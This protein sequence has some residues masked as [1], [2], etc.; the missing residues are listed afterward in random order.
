MY[1]NPVDAA[2]KAARHVEEARRCERRCRRSLP[3]PYIVAWRFMEAEMSRPRLARLPPP[4][5]MA[6]LVLSVGACVEQPPPYYSYSTAPAAVPP[7]A[8]AAPEC[9][10]MH[11]TVMIGNQ[12]QDAVGTACRQPDGTWRIRG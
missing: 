6:V 10:E 8:P 2:E 1:L 4:A 3:R 5:A 7:A 9:R 11:L 12:P